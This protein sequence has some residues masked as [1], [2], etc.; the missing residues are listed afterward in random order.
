LIYRLRIVALAAIGFIAISAPAQERA[1]V[2]RADGHFTPLVIY[3][4]VEPSSSCPPLA[5]ISHGAGGSENGYR[6]LAQPMAQNGFTTVVMGHRESGLA[7]LRSDMRQT[8]A[9]AGRDRAGRRLEC[10]TGSSARR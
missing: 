2:K 4:A 7:A 10:R 6:Y 3:P 5:V 8:R 9:E 1:S